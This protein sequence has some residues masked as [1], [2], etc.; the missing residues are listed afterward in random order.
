MVSYWAD[1]NS[2]TTTW[3]APAGDVVRRMG[4]NIGSGRVT[5]LL[6]DDAT[7]HGPGTQGGRTATA[8]AP[9]TKATMWTVVLRPAS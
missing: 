4:L 8:D 7:A 6:S 3:T 9:A 1:K 2:A 5:T